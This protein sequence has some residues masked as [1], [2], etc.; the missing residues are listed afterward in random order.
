MMEPLATLT[1]IVKT[2]VRSVAVA[3]NFTNLVAE[4]NVAKV[5]AESL[6][7]KEVLLNR[8]LDES[9]AYYSSSRVETVS[10]PVR[11]FAENLFLKLLTL[12]DLKASFTQLF[13]EHSRLISIEAIY[14]P[15][16][17]SALSVVQS[18][19]MFSLKH[20]RFFV[21]IIDG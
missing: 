8:V 3:V 16:V 9:K 4:V 2:I 13:L 7:C 14:V 20:S 10:D 11:A 5:P 6:A 18:A 1:L 12:N 21:S 17:P 19:A 15:S